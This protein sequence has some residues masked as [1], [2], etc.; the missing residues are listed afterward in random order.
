MVMDF[1][2]EDKPVR[3]PF[4]PRAKPAAFCYILGLWRDLDLVAARWQVLVVENPRTNPA[5]TWYTLGISWDPDVLATWREDLP[6]GNFGSMPAE[7]G[8]GSTEIVPVQ[9]KISLL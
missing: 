4:G 1:R 6:D 2:F 3:F 9:C 5:S 7:C 8:S